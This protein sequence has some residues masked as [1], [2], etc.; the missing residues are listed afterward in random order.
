M[1]GG[2]WGSRGGG[3]EWG[4]RDQG[5]GQLGQLLGAAAAMPACAVAAGSGRLLILLGLAGTADAGGAIFN[6]NIHAECISAMM[7][8]MVILAVIWESFTTYLDDRFE[9]NKANRELLSK[10]YKELMILG[11]IG[12]CLIL[13][14]EFGLV[15]VQRPEP[16]KSQAT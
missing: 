10:V 8:I 12:F 9:E 2:E 11:F 3:A 13:S 1:G 6:G 15:M 5:G 4:S 7:V 14:K 16:S